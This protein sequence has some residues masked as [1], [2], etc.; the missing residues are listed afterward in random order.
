MCAMPLLT[1]ESTHEIIALHRSAIENSNEVGLMAMV[2]TAIRFSP[3]ERDW[4]QAYADFMGK[5]FSEVVREAALEYVED[6]ADLLAFQ[7]AIAEDDG[8][9]YTTEEVKRMA[10]MAE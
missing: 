10:M 8:T 6:A 4:I 1:R 2:S 3:E 7:E 9:W 5:S